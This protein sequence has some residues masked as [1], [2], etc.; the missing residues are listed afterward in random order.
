MEIKPSNWWP[1]HAPIQ[2]RPAQTKYVKF[3][4][5]AKTE[6]TRAKPKPISIPHTKTKE[7]SSPTLNCSK[8]R[9]TAQNKS[10]FRPQHWNQVYFD[11]HSMLKSVSMRGHKNQVTIFDPNTTSDINFDT[12]T[13]TKS[14]SIPPL[15]SSHFIYPILKSSQIHPPT[16]I[17]SLFQCQL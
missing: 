9:C 15:K 16:Q 6:L 5:H 4:P 10:W 7:I 14:I 11:R 3:G 1:A 2:C 8:F 17:S 12:K 13:K